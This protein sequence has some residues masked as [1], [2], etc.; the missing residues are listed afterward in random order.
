M[1]TLWEQLSEETR[2]I[3]SIK[4]V[5]MKETYGW[6]Q[7]TNYWEA[8]L[9]KINNPLDLSIDYWRHLKNDLGLETIEETYWRILDEVNDEA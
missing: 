9:S 2:K 4:D 6:M 7:L 8:R 3:L 1:K 5:Y